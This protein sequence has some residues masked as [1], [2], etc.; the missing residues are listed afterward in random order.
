MGLA[1]V[2]KINIITSKKAQ[3]AILETLQDE[4]FV[5]IKEYQGDGLARESFGDKIAEIDYELAGIKFS[6]DFLMPFNESKKSLV[7]K[8]NP[9]MELTLEKIER[10]S[11]E[12]DYQK[13]IERVQALEGKINEAKNIIEKSKAEI[14][15]LQPWQGLDFVPSDEKLPAKISFKLTETDA[16]LYPRLITAL[17]TRLPLSEIRRLSPDAKEIRSVIIY[18]KKQE[19]ELIEILNELGA[20]TFEIPEINVGVSQKIK[21]LNWL[22]SDNENKIEKYGN[23]AA[24]LTQHV[25]DLKIV[26]DYLSWRRDRLINQQ[27]GGYSQKTVSF[28][29]WIDRNL[30]KTLE[31]KLNKITD[32]FI[33]EEL[34]VAED[35]VVPVIFKNKIT[36]PFEMVTKL[37]GAPLSNSPD[38]TPFL[39]P[40]FTL[41]FGMA[42]TDA[43]YGLVMALA[44]VAAIK[45]LKIPRSSQ[46]LLRVLI[47][48]G[49]S[50][51]ILGA[52]TGGWFSIELETLPAVI[53][54]PLIAIR[55]VQPM[56]NPLIIFYISLALGIIQVLTGLAINTWWKI[57]NKE[58]AEG[59]LGSAAWFFTLI[60]LLL[61]AGGKMGML[62]AALGEIGKWLVLIGAAVIVYNGTRG[63]KNI[64]LKPGIGVLSLYGIVG[65]FSDVLSYSR[66]LALG[67]TTGIIGMV[68]NVI[69]GLVFG[70]PWIGWLFALVILVGGHLFNLVV[71]ALGAFIHSGRLQ[72]IEFFPKFLEAGGEM[73]EP[74]FKESKYV[75]IID[76]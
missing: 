73:F 18:F 13:I 71:N 55:L 12:S 75:R 17:Q 53:A 60:F 66:L 9:K 65:Y 37:Y 15:Q 21:D 49:V 50:T 30:I 45:I 46:K 44:I 48:G 33:I 39:A 19:P 22:I 67:L 10:I 54:K 69:A 16:Q 47:W 26:Y 29:G 4:G 52:L 28:F 25:N 34:P 20:K 24:G 2:A 3:E 31:K 1:S 6:L 41:F 8:F 42:M 36:E 68:V 56:E 5:Q 7:E 58:I 23:E 38:P 40:F 74:F 11:L 70:I 27:R 76:K 32:E 43:G 63:T 62:P 35:E 57:K 64:F 72:F 14:V 59:L 51:F 61:F